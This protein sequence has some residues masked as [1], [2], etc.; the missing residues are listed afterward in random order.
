MPDL[1]LKAS[2][3][4]MWVGALGIG[5]AATLVAS[6]LLRERTLPMVMGI[7]LFGGGM[8]ERWRPETIV[9][10]LGL[11]TATCA[12][13]IFAGWMVWNGQKFGAI[14]LLA[15]LPVEV[16]FWIAFALPFPPLLAV[17]RLVLLAWGWSALR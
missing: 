5:V 7:R 8:V 6:H 1:S 2:A 9:V 13:Q 14:L 3:A 15:M 12:L 16:A 11:F 10:L 17:T 4:V